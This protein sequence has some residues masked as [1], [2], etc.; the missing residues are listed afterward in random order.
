MIWL[1]WSFKPDPP[2]CPEPSEAESA[3]TRIDR[4]CTVL[5]QFHWTYRRTWYNLWNLWKIILANSMQF[6]VKKCL[7]E[8]KS[9][10]VLNASFLSYMPFPL[11]LDGSRSFSFHSSGDWLAPKVFYCCLLTCKQHDDISTAVQYK[12]KMIRSALSHSKQEAI[13]ECFTSG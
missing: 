7:P 2:D 10:F 3:Q 12:Q 4:L 5:L 6:V 11:W 8:H 13:A 1:V 9:V